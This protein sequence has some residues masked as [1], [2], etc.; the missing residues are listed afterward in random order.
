[1]TEPDFPA[2]AQMTPA[3]REH[4][5]RVVQLLECWADAA[6]VPLKERR[7]WVNA[8]FLH[9]AVKDAPIEW[10]REQV[11]EGWSLDVLLHG[12]AAANIAGRQ[13][14]HDEGVL[15]A[16][17]YH[18]V[19]SVGW[20]RVGVML[21]LAD[22][23]EPGRPLVEPWL[24]ELRDGVPEASQGA[25]R[26]IATLRIRFLIDAGVPLIPETVDFWNA[27]WSEG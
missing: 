21:Y 3:R 15:S 9:D 17:R 4:V 7:R 12:P 2:W 6:A 14:E 26:R 18:S 11:E 13:G 16:V 20:D 27:L 24:A 1:M 25:L 23:L 22:F 19:G 10:L 5:E 8:A